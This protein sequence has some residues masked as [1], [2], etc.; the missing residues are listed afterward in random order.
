MPRNL[1]RRV[2]TLFPVEDPGLKTALRD[3]ILR[4]HLKD[5]QKARRMLPDGSYEWVQPPEGEPPIN[6]QSWLIEHRGT[7]HGEE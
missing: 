4:I 3:Q 5:N 1:Y 6:S 7:W 2:E